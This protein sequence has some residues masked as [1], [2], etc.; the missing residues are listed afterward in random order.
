MNPAN[1]AMADWR[2]W[3]APLGVTLVLVA[4]GA[5]A[6]S[7]PS[8]WAGWAPATCLPG[9]CFCEG[10]RDQLVRQPANAISSLFFLPPGLVILRRRRPDSMTAV[11]YGLA[12]ILIGL[13]SAWYHASLTFP[14]Q[15]ADVLGMYLVGTFAVM[16]AARR[17]SNLTAGHAMVGY[18]ATNAVLFVLLV[19][20]PAFRRLAFAGLIGAALLLEWRSPR[21]AGRR[22][23]IAAFGCLG[24]GLVAWGLDLTRL[25]CS[26]GSWIQGHAIWHGLTAASAAL[27]YRYATAPEIVP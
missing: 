25:T 15:T 10:I 6:A 24:L 9:A 20:A 2:D 7:L 3:L 17:A 14:A 21:P 22:L 27:F 26:T 5:A 13:G 19:E 16:A 11:G 23:L 1:M 8:P 18:L 12:L 4:L